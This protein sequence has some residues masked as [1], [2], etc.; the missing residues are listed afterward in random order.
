MSGLLSR[1]RFEPFVVTNVIVAVALLFGYEL[2]TEQVGA[3]VNVAFAVFTAVAPVVA[4]LVGRRKTR[5]VAS[6][7][8]A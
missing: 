6:L 4:S 1:I 5:S 8:A 7:E 3:Q 2:A